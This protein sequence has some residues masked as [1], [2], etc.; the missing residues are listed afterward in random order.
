MNNTLNANGNIAAWQESSISAESNGLL[1]R[2][3]SVNIG[4][5]VK[6]GQVLARF[7]AST[8]EADVAQMQANV[9]EAQATL[10][11]ATSN[12]SRARS[13][14]DTGALS[15]QQIEQY[16]TAETSA[17]ARVNAAQAS[18]KAQS[19][20]PVSY[21]H[22]DVYKRQAYEYGPQG[23]RINSVAPGAIRTPMLTNA[24]KGLGITEADI[25]PTMSRIGR[26]GEPREVA[27]GSLFLSSDDA[28]YVHGTVLHVGGGFELL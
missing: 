1:L 10:A 13:I 12:A 11:E 18:L 15:K 26:L 24:L 7:S 14:Q 20:K 6:R 22:L 27:H 4:D 23:I 17:K 21:T 16:I 19:I 5:H 3:V 8:I 28:S 2:E 9:A 25:I